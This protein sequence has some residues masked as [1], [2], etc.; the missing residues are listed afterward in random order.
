MK[1]GNR[2]W[3]LCA[4]PLL[5]DKILKICNSYIIMRISLGD[6][7]NKSEEDVYLFN[8]FPKSGTAEIHLATGFQN[9]VYD[10]IPKKLKDEMYVWVKENLKEEWEEGWNE[11]QFLYKT[12]KKAIGPFKKRLWELSTAEKKPITNALE[13]QFKFLFEQLNVFNTKNT[14]TQYV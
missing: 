10:N 1:L 4:V 3:K 12:R 6:C 8:K 2:L 7:I 14:V 11:E 13:K 5:I 9:I